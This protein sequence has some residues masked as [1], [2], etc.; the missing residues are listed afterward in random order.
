MSIIMLWGAHIFKVTSSNG[1][2]FFYPTKSPKTL[3]QCQTRKS[4]KTSHL[5]Q[6]VWDFCLKIEQLIDYQN[7]HRL[8]SCQIISQIIV[9]A[10]VSPHSLQTHR[11][12]GLET[13]NCL[14]MWLSLCV[15]RVMDWL[16]VLF[17]C[18][19]P[20][21]WWDS[22]WWVWTERS[23]CWNYNNPFSII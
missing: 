5:R 18:L 8:I 21:V 16:P 7:C 23:R 12:G 22:L 4:C 11:S 2:F 6:N 14:Q 17:L 20:S 9:S 15:S 10:L 19:L 1:F 3:L 13:L